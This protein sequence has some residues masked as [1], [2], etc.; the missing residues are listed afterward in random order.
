M[1]YKLLIQNTIFPTMRL[2]RRTALAYVGD[3]SPTDKGPAGRAAQRHPPT[4]G[5]DRR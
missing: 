3:A 5:I 4:R 1:L 2:D